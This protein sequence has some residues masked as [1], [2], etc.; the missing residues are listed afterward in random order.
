MDLG[1]FFVSRRC[2][3]LAPAQLT[4]VMREKSARRRST[5]SSGA[6]TRIILG[7]DPPMPL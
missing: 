2:G 4:R 5:S 7:L 3:K 6:L 1:P